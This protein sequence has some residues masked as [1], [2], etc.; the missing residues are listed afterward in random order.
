MRGLTYAALLGS[1]PF[2]L[3]QHHYGPPRGGPRQGTK[4]WSGHGWGSSSTAT[5][6][7]ASS[8]SSSDSGSQSCS[9]I[10]SEDIESAGNNTLFTRWRPHSHFMAPAGWMNDP[11]APMY[12]PKRDVYHLF[13]Q[14]HPQHI[15]WGNISWGYAT[16][17]DMI[18]W[19]DY[20]GWEDS[21][22]L[23]LGPTGYGN[24]NGLGIFSGTG[25]PVNMQGEEDG[26]LLLFYTSVAHLPTNWQIEYQPF[27]E[28]QSLAYSTD[29]G[30]TWEEYEG[31][32]IINTTTNLPPMNW[33]VTGFRDPFFEPWPA[34]DQILGMHEPHYYAVFGSGIKGVGPRMP[35]WSAP[36]S[37][38]TDWT[39]QG[40]LWEPA[41]NTSLGPIIS[42]ATYGFNFE[43][44]GFFSLPDSD[45]NLHYYINMGTEGNNLTF[46]PS[47]HWALWNEGIVSRRENGSAEFTPIAGGASDWGL[48]Y[49]LTSFNDTKNNRRVQWAWAPEDLVG[50]SGLFSAKQQGFQGSLAL[51]RELFVHETKG[52]MNVNGS[53]AYSREATLE[54]NQDGTFKA[55]TLGIK[56]LADVVEGLVANASHKNFE[57]GTVSSSKV[58]Q[59]GGS[60]HM[61]LK[62]SITSATGACGL[63]I[64]ASPDMTEYTTISYQP[65]NNT[66][67]VDRSMSSTIDGF[68]NASV[69]GYFHPYTIR[70]HDGSYKQEAINMDVFVDGSLVEI[71]INERFALATRIYPSMECSTGFGVYVEDGAEA[72]F[73]G[74]EAWMETL[75]VWPGRP[76]DS[77]SPLIWDTAAETNNYTWW[78]GN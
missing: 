6:G 2:G 55:T 60:A 32:P 22:A 52:V 16:S 24:Y 53:V 31:N 35:L 64:G 76:L 11:C 29:G 7:S 46:H 73:E 69:T 42:T 25:Q 3:A 65:T 63:I 67:I 48:S 58:V 59:Q 43:V 37:D 39:F 77:S 28:T 10:T 50:D 18:T 8:T 70:Q 33:N 62:A 17:K 57:V 66:I 5:S 44:S 38:L 1:V 34:M 21:E 30:K 12:D 47:N 49:A 54:H 4:T 13:Y 41:A 74:V 26:T 61:E 14:W 51:P 20:N 56:P 72:T 19:E 71:Y 75:N 27:T 68:N 15:N 78:S 40:A 23:A 36:A 45:G 9:M